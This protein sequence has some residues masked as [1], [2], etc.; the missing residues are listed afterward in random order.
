MRPAQADA[1]K[2]PIKLDH[3]RYVALVESERNATW[4]QEVIASQGPFSV[5]DVCMTMILL[6]ATRDLMALAVAM[7]NDAV[8]PEFESYVDHVERGAEYV[9]YARPTPTAPETT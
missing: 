8:A 2:R 7:G 5:A 3:D 4:D 9:W 6:R 1:H